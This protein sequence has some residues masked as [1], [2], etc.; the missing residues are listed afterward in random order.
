MRLKDGGNVRAFVGA[1]P[2]PR[3]GVRGAVGRIRDVMLSLFLP[4]AP[5]PGTDPVLQHF[6]P[7][8]PLFLTAPPLLP[9]LLSLPTSLR[10]L[11]LLRGPSKHDGEDKQVGKNTVLPHFNPLHLISRFLLPPPLPPL[12]KWKSTAG[13]SLITSHTCFPFLPVPTT[14]LPCNAAATW[15]AVQSTSTLSSSCTFTFTM[16]CPFKCLSAAARA[17]STSGS[18]GILKSSLRADAR[19]EDKYGRQ[20]TRDG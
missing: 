4:L 16:R 17:A 11:A 8:I 13:P 1:V 2:L 6:L 3:I 20:A 12:P 7:S 19:R 15:T 10:P 5:T 18:S 14:V 9:P